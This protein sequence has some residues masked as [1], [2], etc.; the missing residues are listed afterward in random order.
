M[1][2]VGLVYYHAMSKDLSLFTTPLLVVTLII[3]AFILGSLWTKVQ[4][5]EKAGGALS[6]NNNQAAQ[7]VAVTP[8]PT[9]PP[10]LPLTEQQQK[11]VV[12]D[13][14]LIAGKESAKVK[15]VEFSDFECPFCSR[16]Y[17]DTLGQIKKE[18]ADNGKIAFYYR[19]FPLYSIHK[20]AENAALASEC[21]REQGKFVP[22]HDK[23][24]ENQQ[25]ITASDLK[26]YAQSLGLNTSKF[27]SCLDDKKYKNNVDRDVQLGSQ[28][29]VT[30]T[31][32]FFVNGQRISGAV[33]FTSFKTVI[34]SELNK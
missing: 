28:L 33:P 26:K 7:P 16:F 24:F 12:K 32:A 11:D 5:L 21:A 27:N 6:A 23:I 3:S 34:D 13:A 20:D 25:T 8:P 17:S 18:Y 10:A 22:M 30:G 19:H 14:I 29:G 9:P 2:W 31:P 15:I 4:V 1:R